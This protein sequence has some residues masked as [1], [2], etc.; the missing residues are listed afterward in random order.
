MSNIAEWNIPELKWNL[1]R[2]LL[3]YL[4]KRFYMSQFMEK[5]DEPSMISGNFNMCEADTHL[6]LIILLT[7]RYKLNYTK[8]LILKKGF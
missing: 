3:F 7:G 4:D 1:K 6:I 5:I 8:T 2:L